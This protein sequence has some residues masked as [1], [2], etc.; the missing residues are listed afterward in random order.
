VSRSVINSDRKSLK[1]TENYY[2]G[3]AID[4]RRALVL[5]W[6]AKGLNDREIS[7]KLNVSRELVLRD[8]GNLGLPTNH[9]RTDGAA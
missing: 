6:H 8:R 1:L 4:D 5:E 9:R 3:P 7:E 2:N